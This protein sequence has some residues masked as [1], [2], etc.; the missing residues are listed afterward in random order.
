MNERESNAPDIVGAPDRRWIG[1][2]VSALDE[3]VE[4]YDAATLSRLNRARRAAL[5]ARPTARTA[6]WMFPAALAAA[7]TLVLAVGVWRGLPDRGSEAP[8]A[9]EA[10]DYAMLADADTFALAQDLE[11][12]A[13]LDAQPADG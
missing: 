7:F 8:L 13:W 1:S 6:R 4:R 3:G 10:D 5:A 11:F 2:V 9:L 12:Y